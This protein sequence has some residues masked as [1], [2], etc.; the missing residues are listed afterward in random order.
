LGIEILR[1][2]MARFREDIVLTVNFH[3][4]MRSRGKIVPGSVREGHNVFTSVGKSWLTKLMSWSTI[5]STDVPFTNRRVRWI[6]VGTGAQLE[7]VNVSSLSAPVLATPVDYL[8]P[9]DSVEFV[10]STIV[11]F[12]KEFHLNDITVTGTAIPVTEMG[13]FADVNP[14]I[15]GGVNDGVEDIPHNIGFVNTVLNPSLST[16]PPIAYKAFEALTK[17]VDFTLEV[18]W[19]FRL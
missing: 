10:S 6:G 2:I 15:T 19:D 5:G 3:A 14:A 9:L 17:T 18:H 7:S 11:R 12:I 8:V 1:F 4:Q 16:N 13:L